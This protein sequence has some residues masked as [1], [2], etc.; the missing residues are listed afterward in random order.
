MLR[1]SLEDEIVQVSS[2]TI[3]LFPSAC[4]SFEAS[5]CQSVSL[6]LFLLKIFANVALSFQAF[7]AEKVRISDISN[8][9]PLRFSILNLPLARP[10]LE[11][12]N[13]IQIKYKSDIV[14]TMKGLQIVSVI[15]FIATLSS[16]GLV[17]RHGNGR[18]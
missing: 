16:A 12:P 8:C 6:S 11:L 7:K 9:L 14:A 4:P 5:V 10:H 18:E 1:L 17:R 3:I 15:V 13:P 2:I